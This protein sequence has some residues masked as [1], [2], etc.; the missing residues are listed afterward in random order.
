VLKALYH[1]PDP[2]SH[3]VDVVVQHQT[4]IGW[5]QFCRGRIATTWILTQNRLTNQSNG[6]SILTKLLALKFR[7]MPERWIKRNDDIHGNSTLINERHCK[8]FLHPRVQHLYDNKKY[9]P[10]HDQQILDQPIDEI[11]D[12]NP[13]QIEK[14]LSTN[15]SYLLQSLKCENSRTKTKTHN[16]TKFF[17]VIRTNRN[18]TQTAGPQLETKQQGASL[19]TVNSS[20]SHTQTIKPNIQTP[21]DPKLDNNPRR[22]NDLRPP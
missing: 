17:P 15:E 2:Y 16:I 4:S 6:K 12:K 22:K 9:L 8:I 7:L 5:D 18:H 3:E 13:M 19:S 11:F 10:A 20:S 1:V 14:W 21:P